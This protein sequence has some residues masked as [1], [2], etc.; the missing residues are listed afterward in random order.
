MSGN[1]PAGPSL[2]LP[3]KSSCVAAQGEGGEMLL[4]YGW[5]FLDPSM[6][7]RKAPW[8]AWC[9]RSWLQVMIVSENQVE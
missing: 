9:G 2:D 1:C 3:R 8:E 5:T 6:D 7:L 4:N